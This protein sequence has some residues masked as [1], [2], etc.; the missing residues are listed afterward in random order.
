MAGRSGWTCDRTQGTDWMRKLDSTPPTPATSVFPC[1]SEARKPCAG[2]T[3]GRQA[4]TGGLWGEQVKI[5][6]VSSLC[7]SSSLIA[8]FNRQG[9][10]LINLS[11][12]GRN[13]FHT[14]KGE[15]R[16]F[17]SVAMTTRRFLAE[18]RASLSLVI[19]AKIWPA[20]EE[21]GS[22][23]WTRRELSSFSWVTMLDRL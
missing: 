17:M 22:L 21:E 7:S 10:P 6:Y 1:T 19:S 9:L 23:S 14:S 16:A 12:V 5:H 8:V 18:V 3:L 20:A 2:I 11:S 13:S 4:G 15:G